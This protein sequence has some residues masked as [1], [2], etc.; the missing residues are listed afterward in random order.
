METKPLK[1]NTKRTIIIGFAFF[2]ILMLW[3]VYNT[4]CP[5]FL[6][7]IL[8]NK[9]GGKDTDY[10][11]IVGVM[12]ALD[13]LFALFMLPLFGALSDKTNTKFGKRMPYIVIGTILSAIVFPLI[14]VMYT[15]GSLVGVIVMMCLTLIFMQMYRNPAVALMPDI[16]PKPLRSK[17][18]AFINVVGYVG[19]ILGGA[20]AMVI[21]FKSYKG[22]PGGLLIPF[23]VSC[24]AMIVT[25]VILF[26]KVKENQIH[27]E[28]ADDMKRGEE[29]SELEE[30]IVVDAPLTKKNK[31]SLIIII[32]AV[33]LWFASFNSVETFWSSYGQNHLN[34]SN[35]S[36]FT[37]VLTVASLAAFI[38]A[39]IVAD[40]IG[41][42]WTIVIGL[43]LVII[44]L[45]LISF[46]T[47]SPDTFLKDGVVYNKTPF[48]LY[49]FFA[50]CG[51][52]WAFINCCSYPMVVELA[53]G[54]NVGK[55]T[56][57]YY[58]ASMAAQTLTPIAAG[59]LVYKQGA[60]DIL[61]VY[62]TCVMAAALIVFIF[63]NNVKTKAVKIKKGF[64]AFDQD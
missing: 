11:Y 37:I 31:I 24:V 60:W 52:G 63:V 57:L 44:A 8:V 4:Y 19:A 23:I 9:Y 29:E 26:L 43:G 58:A 2:G 46:V 54:K 25:I 27:V 49:P 50:I 34:I 56:G 22:N 30:K 20:I 28:M 17:A 53:H 61:F 42:K 38:P 6:T 12:M 21:P 48:A 13:N 55:Y 33:F 40:K 41:R 16:T 10:Q 15:I 59:L 39:A 5:L 64:E 32:V 3:Q 62:A 45:M 18:N 1:L 51:V 14:A 47:K 36:L 7:D 35:Y